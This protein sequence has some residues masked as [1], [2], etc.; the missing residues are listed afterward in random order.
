MQIGIDDQNWIFKH[1]ITRPILVFKSSL[2]WGGG[3]VSRRRGFRPI[4][5]RY[6]NQFSQYGLAC[7]SQL[8]AC[9]IKVFSSYF[10]HNLYWY[11][12][13]IWTKPPPPLRGT[14]SKGGLM[15]IGIDDQNCTLQQG[16]PRPILDIK[17]LTNFT[18]GGKKTSLVARGFRLL[19]G[20]KQ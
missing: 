3:G 7:N 18:E 17:P 10:C 6:P 9:N 5:K 4:P 16:I 15:Q 14:S 8:H 20:K 11:E 19:S 12:T 1:Q 13:P 2:L